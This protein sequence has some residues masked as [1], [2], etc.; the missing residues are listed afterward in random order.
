MVQNDY[1]IEKIDFKNVMHVRQS[2]SLLNKVFLDEKFS[3]EWWRW[4]YHENPFGKPLGWIA[5]ASQSKKIIG[6]R[7]FW[8][9]IFHLNG[10][11]KLFYQAVDTAIDPDFQRKGIFSKLSKIALSEISNHSTF[12]YNFPNKNSYPAYIKLKWENIKSNYWFKIPISIPKMI[13]NISCN[14]HCNIDKIEKYNVKRSKIYIPAIPN[15]YST[16]WINKIVQWR[17]GKKPNCDYYYYATDNGQVIFSMKRLKKYD[18]AQMLVVNMKDN[19]FFN[20]IYHFFKELNVSFISYN[21]LNSNFYSLISE[22]KLKFI[23]P[24]EV[25]YV[26]KNCSNSE[27]T[28][29][30]IKLEPGEMDYT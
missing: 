19:Y 10:E 5:K 12:I 13:L 26:I 8:P 3:L 14:R 22:K 16:S 17:F 30:N 2:L 9:W 23:R 7:F 25:N 27:T 21:A 15:L 11:N 29:K 18:E 4:K 6:I 1:E 20:D 24:Y 28:I